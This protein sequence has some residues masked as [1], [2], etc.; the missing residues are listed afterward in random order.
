VLSGHF[1]ANRLL[2]GGE[3]GARNEASYDGSGDGRDPEQPEL[4]Q[5]PGS[6]KDCRAGGAGRIDGGIRHR[7]GDEVDERETESDGDGREAF[8]CALV[9][10]AEDDEQ[11]EEGEQELCDEAGEQRI[12]A[13]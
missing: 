6:L 11:E 4:R 10:R 3:E 9:R 1:F 12:A 2:R 7:D 8:G 13:R 5:R